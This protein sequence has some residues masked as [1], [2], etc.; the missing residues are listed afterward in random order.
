MGTLRLNTIELVAEPVGALASKVDIRK[1]QAGPGFAPEAIAPSA[2]QERANFALTAPPSLPGG[3]TLA[4]VY[5]TSHPT[6]EGGSFQQFV[7]L[8]TNGEHKAPI[9]VRFSD[10]DNYPMETGGRRVLRTYGNLQALTVGG[11]V[12]G[13]LAADEVKVA[14]SVAIGNFVRLYIETDV[15]LIQIEGHPRWQSDIVAAAEHVLS[16]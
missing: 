15:A 10:I 2:A 14:P 3:Y 12:V 5:D 6:P 13:L 7:A 16:L 9:V 8:Y 4:E 11:K 1:L